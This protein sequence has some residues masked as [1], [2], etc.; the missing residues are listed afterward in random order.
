RLTHTSAHLL[1]LSVIC[2]TLFFHVS[3][4]LSLSEYRTLD[5]HV[6]L[7]FTPYVCLSSLSSALFSLSPLS[8][9]SPLLSLRSSLLS[10][11][12]SPLH[13]PLSPLLSSLSLLS[14]LYSLC[15]PLSSPLSSSPSSFPSSLLF[16]SSSSSSFFFLPRSSVLRSSSSSSSSSFSSSSFLPRS[17]VLRSCDC[18][19]DYDQGVH[20]T[21]RRL[22]DQH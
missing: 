21:S 22:K 4:F 9:R 16:S 2:L 18:K 7:F 8:T 6:I 15:L 14:L 17:S 12:L 13:S 1:L 19:W 11:I 10:S 20:T 3:P 5:I